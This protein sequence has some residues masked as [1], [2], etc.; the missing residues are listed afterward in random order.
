MLIK[1]NEKLFA[2]NFLVR[3][4]LCTRLGLSF[5]HSIA[6]RMKN[7]K[8]IQALFMMM[9]LLGYQTSTAQTDYVVTTKNDTIKGTVKYLNYGVEKKVQVTTD[10]GKKNVYSIVNTLAFSMKNELYFPIRTTQGYT[11]MKVLKSGYLSLYAF[12]LPDQNWDGHYLLKKDG[13]GQEVPNLGFKKNMTQLLRDCP[14]VKARIQSG[15]LKGSRINEIIDA[16]N[17]CIEDNTRNQKPVQSTEDAE[18]IMIW[19]TLEKDVNGLGCF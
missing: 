16:Y 15:E 19:E 4:A 13:A 18:K 2:I 9:C 8:V 11:Y 7:V 17:N 1:R 5:D 12:Q 3:V 6:L 10:D 14:D